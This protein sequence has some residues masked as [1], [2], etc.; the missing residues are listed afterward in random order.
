MRL[1][2]ISCQGYLQNSCP[3][4]ILKIKLICDYYN[5]NASPLNCSVV[6][7][8]VVLLIIKTNIDI[9]YRNWKQ[10]GCAN[11]K[12]GDDGKDLARSDRPQMSFNI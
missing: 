6:Y 8:F 12:L 1:H 3:V 4:K 5:A 2:K 9:Y 10:P 7:N 11:F